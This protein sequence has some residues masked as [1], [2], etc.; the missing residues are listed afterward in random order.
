MP[1]CNKRS[2]LV[3]IDEHIQCLIWKEKPKFLGPAADTV[4]PLPATDTTLVQKTQI[5]GQQYSQKSWVK[6]SECD[7]KGLITSAILCTMLWLCLKSF[8]CNR[9]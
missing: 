6:V 5:P 1:A 3:Y 7:K 2:A 9:N 4:C 8:S